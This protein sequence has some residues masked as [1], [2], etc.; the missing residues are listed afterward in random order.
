MKNIIIFMVVCFLSGAS[1]SMEGVKVGVGINDRNRDV[2]WNSSIPYAVARQ[3][4]RGVDESEYVVAFQK[5]DQFVIGLS[6]SARILKVR[7]SDRHLM[8]V[9]KLDFWKYHNVYA[10]IKNRYR[11]FFNFDYYGD[12]Y[13]VRSLRSIGCFQDNPLRYG[14]DDSYFSGD[15]IVFLGNDFIA[16][17][18]T[19]GAVNFSES[20]SLDDWLSKERTEEE[21]KRKAHGNV[22]PYQHLSGILSDMPEVEPGYRGYSKLY[23]GDFDGDENSDILVW[24]KLYISRSSEDEVEGFRKIR[25]EWQ[26][27]TRDES[28]EYIPLDTASAQIQGWLQLNNLTWKKG[29]PAISECEGEEGQLIPEMH[30]PLLNDPDVLQ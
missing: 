16:F 10:E 28:G 26:H 21:I 17:S 2:L 13:S 11:E 7:Y 22:S 12:G 20:F 18:L 24:R 1:F 25:D 4:L 23:F 3:G 19:D 5:I 15:V 27:Y 8:G 6:D 14:G 29:F 9:W 30:D